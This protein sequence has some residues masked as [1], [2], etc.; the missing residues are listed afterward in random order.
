MTTPLNENP[1]K[2]AF[3][4]SMLR[5]FATQ[6]V[7]PNIQ[8]A[9]DLAYLFLAED[10]AAIYRDDEKRTK[11]INEHF[12]EGGYEFMIA[13]TQLIDRLF[14]QALQENRAQIVLLGA[15]FDTRA[16]RFQSL[17]RE[18]QIFEL[19]MPAT[20]QWKQKCFSQNNIPTPEALHFV[21]TTFNL[22]SLGADLKQAGYDP[23]QKTFFILEGVTYFLSEKAVDQTLNFMSS[24]SGSGST[25]IFDYVYRHVI[26]QNWMDHLNRTTGEPFQF[27]IA[28]GQIE[29]FLSSRGLQLIKNYSHSELEQEFLIKSDGALFNPAISIFCLAHSRIE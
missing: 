2:T 12:K 1:S 14:Q 6:E 28:E 27:G 26:E 15:G 9:D 13:R 4:A 10:L 21:P 11:F 23:D 29:R 25:L 8:G 5:A 19:E 24:H 16:W 18:T 17:I 7:D 3:T 20:Q 22:D